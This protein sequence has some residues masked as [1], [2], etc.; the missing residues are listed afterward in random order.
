MDSQT[1]FLAKKYLDVLIIKHPEDIEKN[2]SIGILVCL[3]TA[4]KVKSSLW[5]FNDPVLLSSL[6]LKVLGLNQ[7]Y[8]KHSIKKI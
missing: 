4:A 3:R 7:Y 2:P 5:K 8:E 6:N 1:K